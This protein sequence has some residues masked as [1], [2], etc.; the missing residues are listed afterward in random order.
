MTIAVLMPVYNPD[1]GLKLTIESLRAQSVPFKL[2]L[3]DDGSKFHA[4]Y[5]ALTQGIDVAI[6]RLAKNV[7]IT[8][9]MNAG[10][11][12]IMKGD[13]SYIARID[14]GDIATPD[15]F[16]KQLA[17][18]EA[19]PE[20]AILG[21]FVEL[22]DRDVSGH[23]KSTRIWSLPTTSELCEKKMRYN[24]AAC[25][26]AMMIRRCVFEKLKAYSDE[27][28]AAE[29][30]ELTWR[31]IKA[32]FRINNLADVLLIKEETPDSISQKRRRRQIYS[33]LRIQMANH[34]STSIH[35]WLGISR[36]AATLIFPSEIIGALK[37]A[38]GKA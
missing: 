22:R 26:P 31:A 11:T 7:G 21:S 28:A 5:E 14:A 35:S 4:E 30:F 16:A 36:S 32:E 18:L 8:G 10:L 15:R 29:D 6:L 27:Y 3:V 24:V 12:E 9:A 38:F 2:Y 20:I 33:R 23:L 1:D 17:Y 34:K 37:R 13:Y 19:H 25:H